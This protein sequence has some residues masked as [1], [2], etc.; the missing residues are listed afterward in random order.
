M[1]GLPDPTMSAEAYGT[2]LAA[3]L[4]QATVLDE[5]LL[6]V[7]V[8]LSKAYDSVRLDLLEFLLCGSGLLAEVWRPM[9]D[10]ARAR[11]RIKVMQAVGGWQE[12]T[13]GMLPGCPGATF[14][15]SIVLERWRRDTAAASPTTK[16][17]CWVDDS[18]ASGKGETNGLATLVVAVRSMEDLEQGD[19]LRVNRKKSGTVVSHPGL[20][21]LVE[22]AAKVRR[23]APFGLWSAAATWS[24][25]AGSCPGGSSCRR[26][27]P[28]GLSGRVAAIRRSI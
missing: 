8:D 21:R 12:P 4:E 10:M 14:V 7:C 17:R 19:G 18:T 2:L 25:P 3:E 24:H 26:M 13:S 11:R 6:A 28:P 5:P 27:P 16:V 23:T 20:R 1:E 9:L 15:M 22:A